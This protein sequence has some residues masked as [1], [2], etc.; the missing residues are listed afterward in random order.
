MDPLRVL[1]ATSGYFTTQQAKGAGYGDRQIAAMVRRGGWLR[2]RRGAYAFPDEWRALDAVGRHRVRCNA[3]MDSLGDK[4]ALSHVSGVLLH[5]L[6]VWN[7]PLDRVHVTRLDGGSGRVEGDVVHHEGLVGLNEVDRVEG[8]FITSAARCALEA[9]SR[10]T[11]ESALVLFDSGLRQG[12]FTRAELSA[13]FALL[14]HWPFMRHLHVP[15]RMTDERAG[16]VGESRGRWW[17]RQLG[18][19]AP[20]LQQHVYDAE[21]R[22]LGVTDWWW[23][24]LNTFGEFDGAIK[25]GRLLKP[26]QAPGDVVFME[27]VREDAIRAVTQASFIRLTWADFAAPQVI[28]ERFGLVTRRAS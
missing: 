14:E 10:A 24:E 3:V 25:Y 19:P 8:R 12:A 5:G 7:I 4:V 18:L 20:K 1:T 6:D 27:K 13:T 26:G 16:S 23:P 11:N 28:A 17:F 9:G 22:L 2:F 21:G 15:V